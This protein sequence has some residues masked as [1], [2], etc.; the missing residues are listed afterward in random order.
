V[1][2]KPKKEETMKVIGFTR[3]STTKQNLGMK[4]QIKMIQDYCKLNNL[5]LVE[6]IKEEGISGDAKIRYGF[7]KLNEMVANKEVD[8]V[9]TTWMSRIGRSASASIKFIND[10]LDMNVKLVG[11]KDGIDTSTSGGRMQAKLMAVIA[12]EE[13]FTIRQRI[14]DTI[15]H[16]KQSGLK[17]N[18]SLA[19]GVYEKNGVLYEDDFEMK[20]VRNI[21]NWRSRGWSWYKCMKKLNENDIPTKNR[22]NG[23]T[24]N[25]VKRTINYHYGDNQVELVS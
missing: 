12:E 11:L 25:Q 17:Y 6:I 20:V 21:K 24:I 4:T 8:G 1:R 7:D 18:G 9:I 2:T 5:E 22:G 10:C 3:V 19:Y 23:W 15:Q 16:K 13:L 14:K